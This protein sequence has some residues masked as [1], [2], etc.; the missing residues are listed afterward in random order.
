[1]M[2][3]INAIIM[4]MSGKRGLMVLVPL[5]LLASAS[6]IIPPTRIRIMNIKK[7]IMNHTMSPI[8]VFMSTCHHVGLY[9]AISNISL[10]GLIKLVV[11]M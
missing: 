6:C 7:A 1:M 4:R 2:I 5:I 11:S 9:G 10:S 8:S 3:A